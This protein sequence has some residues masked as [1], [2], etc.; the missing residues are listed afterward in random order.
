MISWRM[1]RVLF[2]ALAGMAFAPAALAANGPPCGL[3]GSAVAPQTIQYDPFATAGLQN[4]TIPFT[5]NRAVGSGGQKTQ[6]VYFIL[7]QPA[8]GPAYQMQL[9]F[10][11]GSTYS[12]FLYYDNAIPG[13][14][15]TAS[16]NT[17]GQV[18]YN[19]LGASQPDSVTATLTVTI[20]PLVNVNAGD[21]IKFNVRYVCDG[22]GGMS[23]VTSPA[24]L[25]DAVTINVN[26]I[27]ALRASFVGDF[28]VNATTGTMAFGEIGN[29]TNANASS[30]KTAANNHVRVQSNAPYAVS[31]TSALGYTMNVGGTAT[32]DPLQK[33]GYNLKFLSQTRG[34]GNTGAIN[35]DCLRAGVGDSL[36]D[37][38][39]I[40]AQ[41]AE[42]GAGKA[43]SGNY[44]DTLTVTITPKVI[45][46]SNTGTDC[47]ASSGTF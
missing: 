36:E 43:P 18:Y 30:K 37:N 35:V 14:L 29:I 17:P 13:G 16:S 5:L 23:D 7:T 46:A 15:P 41:L 20:P 1:L 3:S 45:T 4:I 39:F 11:G 26:V 8:G 32:A 2:S 24:V 6:Q 42:G 25:N 40:Q 34:P 19:F 47:P 28:Y 22:T 21:P 9:T 31:L 12:N 27:S 33:I 44:F 10:P 38:L